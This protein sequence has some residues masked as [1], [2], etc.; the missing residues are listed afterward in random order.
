MLPEGEDLDEWL[1]VHG[2]LHILVRGSGRADI[3]GE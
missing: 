2:N 1:A 3:N